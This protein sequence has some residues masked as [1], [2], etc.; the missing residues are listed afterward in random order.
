M[1][2][3]LFMAN[4]FAEVQQFINENII[5]TNIRK[6]VDYNF[7]PTTIVINFQEMSLA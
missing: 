3:R 5:Q 6:V 4:N 2:T 7:K 1:K